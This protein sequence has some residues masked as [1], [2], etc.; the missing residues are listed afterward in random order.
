MSERISRHNF[1]KKKKKMEYLKE[2]FTSE[3]SFSSNLPQFR[4]VLFSFHQTYC[5]TIV[6]F[7]VF[8]EIFLFFKYILRF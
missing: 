7:I 4:E 1:L 3:E 5:F 8:F 2:K 6:N